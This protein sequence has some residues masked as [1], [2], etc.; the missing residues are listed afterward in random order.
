MITQPENLDIILFDHQLMNIERMEKLETKEPIE[1]VDFCVKNSDIGILSDKT[2]SGKSFCIIGLLCRDQMKWE[3]NK[4]YIEYI[5]LT[6]FGNLVKKYDI[7]N[8]KKV[9]TNLIVTDN[10]IIE[11]WKEYLSFS[12]LRVYIITKNKHILEISNL[13]DY[14]VILCNTKNFNSFIS[15]NTNIAWKRFIYD[16]PGH[17]KI[18]KMKNINAGFTWFI[19]ATPN[20]ILKLHRKS[21]NNFIKDKFLKDIFLQ[22]DFNELLEGINIFNIESDIDKS[23]KL[24]DFTDLFYD[25]YLPIYN[26]IRG[27]VSTEIQVLIE[28]NNIEEAIYKL[29]GEFTCN[30]IELIKSNMETQIETLIS[31]LDDTSDNDL[32]IMNKISTIKMKI[33]QLNSRYN[34]YIYQSCPICLETLD[35]PVLETTC[36]NLFCG[37]CILTWLQNNDKCPLCIQSITNKNIVLVNTGINTV[38][39]NTKF[40]RKLTKDDQVLQIIQDNINNKFIIY[41]QYIQSFKTIVK[42]FE[43]NNIKYIDMKGNLEDINSNILIYKNS[44]DV[45]VLLL[46]CKFIGAGLNLQETTDIIF[47]HNVSNDLRTQVIGRAQR[48]GRHKKLYIHNLKV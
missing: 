47:Y 7:I 34:D 1:C 27:L 11:Q 37:K 46:N 5:N 18:S 43:K 48:A 21:K 9:N 35:K 25:C 30:I 45:N 44:T 16:E 33:Q 17:Y 19:S 41:S 8:L 24:P 3:I 26:I 22:D 23:F 32:K 13:N 40:K 4:P 39:I 31:L 6:K 14:D 38:E 29:G 28:S 36:Q 10:C 2:G 20:E 12:R 15:H 42:L